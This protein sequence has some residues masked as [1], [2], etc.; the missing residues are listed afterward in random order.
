M[1][2]RCLKNK[3]A[4]TEHVLRK[5][6]KVKSTPLYGGHYTNI[7]LVRSWAGCGIMR[8][9]QKPICKNHHDTV[10]TTNSDQKAKPSIMTQTFFDFGKQKKPK[11]VGI[12]A[13]YRVE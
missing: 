3:N 1:L 8:G 4:S 10:V 9:V 7:I 13:Q 12:F 6:C 11:T 2:K 5:C